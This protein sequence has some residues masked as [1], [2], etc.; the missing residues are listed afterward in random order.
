MNKQ[1]LIFDMD[2]VLVNVSKSYRIA[3]KQTAEFFIKDKINIQEV[4]KIKLKVGFNNDWDA[5]EAIIVSKGKK[6]LKQQIINK[7]QE[8]YLGKN[9]DGLIKNEKWMLDKN[10][11]KKLSKKYVLSIFTGRPRIEAEFALKI[12]NVEKY[13]SLLVAKEDV[14]KEKPDPE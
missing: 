6:M 10:I 9:F 3:I 7:F 14:L 8:Y 1:I 5:T 11:L 2:G 12:N 4:N 13:F